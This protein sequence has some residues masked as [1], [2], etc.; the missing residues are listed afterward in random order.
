MHAKS[1]VY[2]LNNSVPGQQ[3]NCSFTAFPGTYYIEYIANCLTLCI[4]SELGN[5]TQ[6]TSVSLKNNY[7]VIEPVALLEFAFLAYWLVELHAH[8]LQILLKIVFKG[9][10]FQ[11]MEIHETRSKARRPNT[12]KRSNTK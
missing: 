4:H 12:N 6:Y 10:K 9:G 1:I 7:A 2:Y 5:C 11:H 3:H 8:C